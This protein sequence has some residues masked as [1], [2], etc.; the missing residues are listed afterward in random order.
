MT[1]SKQLRKKIIY[2]SF[3]I[4]MIFLMVFI[5]IIYCKNQIFW[6]DELSSIQ[7]ISR[8][9]SFADSIKIFYTYDVTN[10]PLYYMLMYFSYRILNYSF[11]SLILPGIIF[12]II[13]IL[14]LLKIIKKMFGNI[15]S[16]IILCL[17]V[18]SGFFISN[19][20]WEVRCYGLL[21]MLSSMFIY[22]YIR[23]LENENYFNIIIYGLIG[24]A[25]AYTHWFGGILILFYFLTDLYLF[26]K[27]RIKF[28]CILSYIL[29]AILFLPWIYL[30][31]NNIMIDLSS[32]WPSVPTLDT[33][34]YTINN[35]LGI[36]TNYL[37]FIIFL[38]AIVI[39]I[40]KFIKRK[41]INF[42]KLDL[43]FNM[44]L[45]I[46]FIVIGTYIYSVYICSKRSLF[47]E[48]YFIVILPAIYIIIAY[49]INFLLNQKFG[50]L[51]KLFNK[52]LVSLLFVFL[53]YNL[54]INL[55][56]FFIQWDLNYNSI[57]DSLLAN[58]DINCDTTLIINDAKFSNSGFFE[59]YFENRNHKVP[60][61]YLNEIEIENIKNYD[62]VYF[63][64]KETK[65]N[66][67]IFEFLNQNYNLIYYDV[68]VRKYKKI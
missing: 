20:L 52:I 23:R 31:V 64:S 63:I 27:H 68:N 24:L 19:I 2:V 47:V 61:N 6:K 43:T 35:L 59:Y 48:R 13:G 5:S 22:F 41:N 57:A 14:F 36:K 50:K 32:F 8:H 51:S 42:N 55:K 12:S 62:T 44:F 15:T 39:L 26:L 18:F 29:I 33:I 38:L 58:D 49:L 40:V 54:C 16:L 67:N 34:V 17:I 25:L 4:L 46:V 60:K 30:L 37:F 9:L 66:Y 21:F 3:I 7:F 65:S 28:K 53:I 45:S 56:Y 11:L 1:N 10:L